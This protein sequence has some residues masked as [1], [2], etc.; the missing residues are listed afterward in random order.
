MSWH[1]TTRYVYSGARLDPGN[2]DSLAKTNC[3]LHCRRQTDGPESRGIA[4]RNVRHG[5]TE[6]QW[7]LLKAE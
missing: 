3:I 6:L 4:P 7:T 1:Y 5:Q 2:A